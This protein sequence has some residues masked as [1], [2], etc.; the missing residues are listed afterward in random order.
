MCMA[1]PSSPAR[2]VHRD[3][4]SPRKTTSTPCP[5]PAGELPEAVSPLSRGHGHSRGCRL[6]CKSVLQLPKQH[7]GNSAAEA[8]NLTSEAKIGS[9]SLT[10]GSES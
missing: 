9:G 6:L 7:R 10:K 2:V 4:G 5:F 3:E 1:A 8:I